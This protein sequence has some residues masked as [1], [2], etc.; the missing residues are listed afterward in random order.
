MPEL[1]VRTI[2]EIKEV[3][4]RAS[5]IALKDADPAYWV[6]RNPGQNITIIPPYRLGGEE[7]PKTYGHFHEP[8]HEESYQ[9]L[10]GKAGVLMQWVEDGM[11]SKIELKIFNAGEKFTVPKGAGHVLV[12]LGSSYLI[13]VDDHDP[14]KVSNIYDEVR[15]THGFGYYLVEKNGKLEAIPNPA[16]V[17]LPTLQKDA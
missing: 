9:V 7:F 15:K 10:F 5:D 12:N 4:Y 6:I 14:S 17:N 2:G 3:A 13:T 8:A 11:V 16:F 1:Q